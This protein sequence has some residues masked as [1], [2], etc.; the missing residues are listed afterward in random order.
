M[1][2]HVKGNMSKTYGH[3]NNNFKK[4]TSQF[5]KPQKSTVLRMSMSV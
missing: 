4:H 1:P 5:N 3:K 2:M